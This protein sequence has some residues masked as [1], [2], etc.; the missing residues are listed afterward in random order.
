MKLFLIFSFVFSAINIFAECDVNENIPLSDNYRIHVAVD[1]PLVFEENEIK[2]KIV[3]NS[4]R[5]YFSHKLSESSNWAQRLHPFQLTSA[6]LSEGYCYLQLD[7][8]S[9]KKG[10]DNGK[11]I[12]SYIPDGQASGCSFNLSNPAPGRIGGG[13]MPEC[14]SGV[15]KILYF[16]CIGGSNMVSTQKIKELMGSVP[17]TIRQQCKE[18]RHIP[19]KKA[20][21]DCVE[22]QR[23]RPELPLTETQMKQAQ[24][25]EN[26]PK[27]PRDDRTIID[28]YLQIGKRRE[29]A[30]EIKKFQKERGRVLKEKLEKYA[31]QALSSNTPAIEKLGKSSGTAGCETPPSPPAIVQ[32]VE[33]KIKADSRHA[34]SNNIKQEIEDLKIKDEIVSAMNDDQVIAYDQ[35]EENHKKNLKEY[36]KK[37]S[38]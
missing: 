6:N 34:Q 35:A 16:D 9:L 32:A 24:A 2:D 13:A 17:V 30:E 1:Y 14:A 22:C 20:S 37:C 8:D 38:K 23:P 19:P 12:F 36:Y 31:N 21:P 26:L 10:S 4:L 18:A 3:N 33:D 5:V 11:T 29:A 7:L 28:G 25:L 27:G 15:P